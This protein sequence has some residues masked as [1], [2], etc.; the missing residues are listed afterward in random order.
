MLDVK[1]QKIYTYIIITL[2]GVSKLEKAKDTFGVMF[3]GRKKDIN[4]E[5]KICCGTLRLF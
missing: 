5:Q 3:A 4:K 2:I 1:L